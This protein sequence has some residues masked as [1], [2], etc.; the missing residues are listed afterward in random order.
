MFLQR[1][2][3]LP[4]LYMFLQRVYFLPFFI[5]VSVGVTVGM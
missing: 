3:F 1:V 4:F 2:H 5:H